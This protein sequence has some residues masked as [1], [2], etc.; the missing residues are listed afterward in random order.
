[1]FR[2]RPGALTSAKEGFPSSCIKVRASSP[3]FPPNGGFCILQS[4]V[5]VQ[6]PKIAYAGSFCEFPPMLDPLID[7]TGLSTT[8]PGQEHGFSS[9]AS[10]HQVI[11]IPEASTSPLFP[12]ISVF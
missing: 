5:S 3:G 9:L 4:T 12:E 1:M 10:S 2:P 7:T 8:L 11:S 6:G